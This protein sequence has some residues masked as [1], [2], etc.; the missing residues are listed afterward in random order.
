[1]SLLRF[2]SASVLL[3]AAVFATQAC[4]VI[5]KS[6]IG[7]GHGAKCTGDGECQSGLCETGICT[8]RCVADGECPTGSVCVN[9][10]C[11]VG[12]CRSDPECTTV[13]DI[14]D[15]S[16]QRCRPGCRRATEAKCGAG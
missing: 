8:S 15:E 11:K 10:R 16:A 12:G 14:C 9:G 13:G 4:S 5:A 6:E 1:M 2:V 7:L 3:A